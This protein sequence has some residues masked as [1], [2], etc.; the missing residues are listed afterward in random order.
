M[1]GIAKTADN[2]ADPGYCLYGAKYLLNLV[3]VL[4]GEIEGVRIAEDIEY[5]HRMRVATRRIRAA[6]PLYRDCFSPKEFRRWR[7]EIRSITR[8]LGEARDADVQID[9]LRTFLDDL[10]TAEPTTGEPVFLLGEG[11]PEEANLPVQAEENTESL[12][13]SGFGNRVRRALSG[14][15]ARLSGKELVPVSPH[16]GETGG[17]PLPYGWDLST[18]RLRPGIDCLILRLQQRREALQ[19]DV[20]RALEH[21]VA[22]EMIEDMEDALRKVVVSGKLHHTDIHSPFAYEQ[23]FF[24]ISLRL[25]EIFSYDK[26]VH[27]PDKIEMHHAMRIA[28]K[29]LRYTMECFAALYDD[30]LKT[31]I[32]SVKNLQDILGDMHDCDVWADMLPQFMEEE[33]KRSEEY[34]GHERFFTFMEPG[35]THLRETRIEERKKLF[36]SLAT[37]WD[38]MQKDGTWEDLRATISA[39]LQGLMQGDRVRFNI[40]ENEPIR[41]ALLGD[42]H[43]NLPALE[44][45]LADAKSRG[46]TTLFNVGDFVGYGAFPEETVQRLKEEH[47]ISTVGNYDLNVLNVRGMKK[48][49]KPRSRQKRLSLK[50]AYKHLSKESRAYLRSLPRELR[51]NLGGM[52]IY[53]THGSPESITDHITEET[54]AGKLHRFKEMADADII[55]TG[56]A[57]QPFAKDVDGTWFVNTG[58][59]GRPDDGDP[60]ACYALLQ[61]NPFALYHFR[62][63]YDI[64]RAVT[65]I[66]ENKLPDS[67]ARIFQE[68]RPL[69]IVKHYEESPEPQ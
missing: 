35:L 63:P 21:L 11:T 48:K 30:N 45:V 23:A 54:S 36:E 12:P 4:S 3:E 64:E 56:H 69:D 61:L 28:A 62:V 65:A 22:E 19:P 49:T 16:S 60:R 20:I 25:E 52:H 34:F 42:V 37:T 26:Y 58:S 46:A 32:T 27:M 10:G 43:A 40:D 24:H 17:I 31:Q 6:L 47:A 14:I 59:V 55:V 41:I 1:S 44:A 18:N 51:L 67:F 13:S 38:A 33:K 29:R 8:A 50:W 15:R 53:L 9:Y 39:P 68:G 7:I 5:V 2:S 57:H 66:Y